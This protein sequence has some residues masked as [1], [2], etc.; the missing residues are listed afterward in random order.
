[1][2]AR[3]REVTASIGLVL[4][5]ALWGLYWLPLR[6]LAD[7][8]LPGAWS[9]LVVY[10]C[11]ALAIGALVLTGRMDLRRP[12]LTLAICGLAT[13]AAFSLYSTSLV[14][15]DVVRAILLF[16]LTPIWGTL[17]GRFVLGEA[18]TPARL[19]A[20]ALA[21]AGLMVVL[22]LGDGWPM[23]RNIGDWLALASGLAWAYG[24]LRVY[25]LQ[26]ISTAEQVAAFVFGALVVTGLTMLAAPDLFVANT[27]PLAA[28][29]T[30]PWGLLMALYVLPM[31]VLTIGPARL[32][33]PGRVGIL[34]MSDVLVDVLSAAI[35]SGDP[36]G[37][38][39]ALG[40]ALI[41]SAAVI[42]VAGPRQAQAAK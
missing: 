7:L 1:M 16:Y 13:G 25:Q 32:L 19:V 8:G 11:C 3:S 36:F 21:L 2:Q 29:R 4:G 14:F 18:L 35:W 28:L 33:T 41:I 15:T 24:S 20:L 23:P 30:L 26:D 5:G 6:F 40:S 12:S 38:R 42:E 31:L 39:E 9:S 27:G 17:L 22:G 37:W 34:L 10:L